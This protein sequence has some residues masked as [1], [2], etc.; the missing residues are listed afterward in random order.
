MFVVEPVVG[1]EPTT[2]RLQVACATSCATPASPTR[3]RHASVWV[4]DQ[5]NGRAQS[6]CAT[7]RTGS[8]RAERGASARATTPGCATSRTGDHDLATSAAC[9][10]LATI[11][12]E[13][14]RARLC[15][16]R[17]MPQGRGCPFYGLP[18]RCQADAPTGSAAV[19]MG[20][21]FAPLA[22]L[23]LTWRGLASSATGTRMVRTPSS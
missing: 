22:T 5:P 8:L 20:C 13:G 17:L 14:L 21:G 7:S 2:W 9:S 23:M 4:R 16:T 10:L 18:S 1:L 11:P 6:G 12:E 19:S 3:I 15:R